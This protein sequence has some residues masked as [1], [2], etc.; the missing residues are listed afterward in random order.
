MTSTSVITIFVEV[1]VLI[2]QNGIRFE[3]EESSFC[4]E[5][6]EIKKF[7]SLTETLCRILINI[8]PVGAVFHLK[9]ICC[10]IRRGN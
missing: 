7:K 6:E 2:A 5:E 9:L 1:I 4:A 10:S 3:L 8:S